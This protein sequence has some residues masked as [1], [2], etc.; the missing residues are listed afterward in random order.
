MKR[1]K[2]IIQEIMSKTKCLVLDM[3][4]TIYLSEAPIGDMVNTLNLCREKGIQIYF[5]TNNS[6]KTRDEYVKKLQRINLFDE[7]DTVYT[8]A[9]ATVSYINANYPDKTVYAV[10][11]D[12]VKRTL[13]ESGLRLVEENADIVLLAYDTTLTFEKLKKANEMIV[14]G[15]VYIATHPD[16][17]CPT[18][19]IYMP[20]VGSF[21]KLLEAS[22]GGRLP[23]A[24]IGKPNSLAGTEIMRATGLHS[25]EITMV[26]DRLHTDILFG[27]NSGFNTVLVL[28]GEST[29]EDLQ[30]SPV[31]PTFVFNDLNEI[32]EYLTR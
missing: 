25:H 13:A 2:A 20:D 6:S 12:P 31:K 23:D 4:G 1:E 8:S 5:F 28:S 29:E 9:M 7:R 14:R 15:A 22:S 26:G 19:D 21:I 18:D 27:I 11:T 10:A 16:T 17:V 3:D 30:K 24:V 32:T